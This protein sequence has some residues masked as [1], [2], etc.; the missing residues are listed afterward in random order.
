M[1]VVYNVISSNWSWVKK[2][3]KN[4]ENKDASYTSQSVVYVYAL[5]NQYYWTLFFSSGV[6]ASPLMTWGTV[7]GTPM[8]LDGDVTATP[9]TCV[10][11]P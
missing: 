4:Q 11:D 9:G 5:L 1:L 10:Q 8:R 2:N 6:D 3:Q 7:D